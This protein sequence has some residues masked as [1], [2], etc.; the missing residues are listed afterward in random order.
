MKLEA[1]IIN[2]GKEFVDRTVESTADYSLNF[3]EIPESLL[4]MCSNLIDMMR[5][6]RDIFGMYSEVQKIEIY[7]EFQK[8]ISALSTSGFSTVTAERKTAIKFENGE[9]PFPVTLVYVNFFK[10]GFEPKQ[11]LVPKE[12][13]FNF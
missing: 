9:K 13:S 11:F 2:T 1:E 8:I 4:E 6:V 12:I 5:E 3:D 10:K 7:S